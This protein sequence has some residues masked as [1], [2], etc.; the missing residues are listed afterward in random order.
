MPALFG[1]F[2]LSPLV[3]PVAESTRGYFCLKRG[4]VSFSLIDFSD[5]LQSPWFSALLDMFRSLHY[6]KKINKAIQFIFFDLF[7]FVSV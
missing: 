3:P 4:H 1:V 6:E 7:P 2:S 5:Q